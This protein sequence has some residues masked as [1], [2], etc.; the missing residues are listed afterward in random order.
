METLLAPLCELSL[1][2]TSELSGRPG[3]IRFEVVHQPQVQVRAGASISAEARGVRAFGE[4]VLAATQTYDGWVRLADGT[5][6]LPSFSPEDGPLLLCPFF[7]QQVGWEKS[8]ALLRRSLLHGPV[9]SADVGGA[10]RELVQ[11]ALRREIARGDVDRLRG[12]V[13]HAK[14]LGLPTKEVRAA[15][16]VAEGLRRAWRPPARDAAPTPEAQCRGGE[17]QHAEAQALE[18][19]LERLAAAAAAGDPAQVRLARGVAAAAGATKKEIARVYS[20]HC[21]GVAG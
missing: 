11:D 18:S 17:A 6:W 19:A 13:F 14:A 4:I 2:A 7:E 20:L 12:A 1:L 8:R 3:P 10:A 15:E 9:A 16:L 21:A 5:G